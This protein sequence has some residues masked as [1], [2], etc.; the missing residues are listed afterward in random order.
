MGALSKPE[1]I[2]E[3][4]SRMETTKKQAGEFLDTFVN[5][6]YEETRTH[7]SFVIPG[8]G[9]LEIK[10]KAKNNRARNPKTGE[11]VKVPAKNI[12]RFTLFRSCKQTILPPKK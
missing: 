10:R 8:I 4:A 12:V 9:K 1:L 6:A 7:G 5:L 3:L 2:A 11:V